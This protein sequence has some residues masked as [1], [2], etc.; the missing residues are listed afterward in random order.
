VSPKYAEGPVP[1]RFLHLQRSEVGVE[2]RAGE[3]VLSGGREC[4]GS[5]CVCSKSRIC[6]SVMQ[7]WHQSSSQSDGSVVH[8]LY[9]V[10]LPA[11]VDEFIRRQFGPLDLRQPSRC[12]LLVRV[13]VILLYCL[14][15]FQPLINEL[16][17]H[18]VD[19]T[20]VALNHASRSDVTNQSRRVY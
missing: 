15:L 9:L 8:R 1:L 12:P 16:V 5:A 10:R 4:K 17:I 14:V 7:L 11:Y 19:G 13:G 18:V 2:I 20:D 6:E 3:C